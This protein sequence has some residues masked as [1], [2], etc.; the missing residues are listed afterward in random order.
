[1]A[2]RR[3]ESSANRFSAICITYAG[4]SRGGDGLDGALR[5]RF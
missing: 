3:L 2:D 1:M 5:A 4:P